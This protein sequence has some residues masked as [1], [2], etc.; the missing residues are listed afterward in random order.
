[1]SGKI[2]VTTGPM[3]SAKTLDIIGIAERCRVAG[4]QCQIFHPEASSRW[5]KDAIV[6]RL[7]EGKIAFSSTPLT[8][9]ELFFTEH[10]RPGTSVVIFDEAQFY[11]N[12]II[13]ICRTLRSRNID[14]HIAGLDMD[15]F[16]HPF[17]PMPELMAIADQ[18][19]KK[20]G[21]CSDCVEEGILSY[22]AFSIEDAPTVTEGSNFEGVGDEEYKCLC[23]DCYEARMDTILGRMR[24]ND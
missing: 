23:V 4:R 24:D 12:S 1:L 3:R 10:L 6:S 11:S 17:G 5:D 8:N 13:S 7:G 19:I 9:L 22:R 16:Q 18:V 2:V 20:T 14:V 21:I 15:V